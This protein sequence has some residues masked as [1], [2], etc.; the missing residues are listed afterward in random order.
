MLSHVIYPIKL[1][2]EL[3]C[4]IYLTM[5]VLVC[6]SVLRCVALCCSVLQLTCGTYLTMCVVRCYSVL[7]CIALCVAA[8][9]WASPDHVCVIML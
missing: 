8:D 9:L 4:K 6:C 1:S 2:S 3:T 5:W 7:R